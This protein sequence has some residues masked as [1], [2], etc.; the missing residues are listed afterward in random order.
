MCL[1]TYNRNKHRTS[2][3]CFNQKLN[4][5]MEQWE[6]CLFC[7]CCLTG[8]QGA[9]RGSYW[10]LPLVTSWTDHCDQLCLLV[11]FSDRAGLVVS[12]FLVQSCNMVSFVLSM[13]FFFSFCSC[14]ISLFFLNIH[15]SIVS[16]S[17]L[18]H[19]IFLTIV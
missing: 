5:G 7:S 9:L 17:L 11:L 3:L 4:P 13:F 15:F 19:C 6:V 8:P 12:F 16:L 10:S 1:I 14:F 2:S 18:Y